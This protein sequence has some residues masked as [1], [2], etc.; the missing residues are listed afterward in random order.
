MMIMM[1]KIIERKTNRPDIN[2]SGYSI[3]ALAISLLPFVFIQ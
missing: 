3:S 1:K 2:G